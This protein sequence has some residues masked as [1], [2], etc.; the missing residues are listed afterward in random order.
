MDSGAVVRSFFAVWGAQDIELTLAHTHEAFVYKVH[1][2]SDALPFGGETR[3]RE[4]YRDLL[5]TILTD[6]DF[7]TY[8]PTIVRIDGNTVR[9]RVRFKYLHRPS[10]ET[11]EGTRRLIIT[12]ASGLIVRI[13]GYHDARLVDAF[14]R[15]TEHRM[16]TNRERRAPDLP[17]R[18]ATEGSGAGA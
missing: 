1:V 8:E 16:A 4:A 11:L 5:F 12:V 7:L 15:L 17:S 6:F 10:G 9:S 2:K 18:R 13:V 3:G 14:L